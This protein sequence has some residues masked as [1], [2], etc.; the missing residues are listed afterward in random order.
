MEENNVK[1]TQ[2]WMLLLLSA[3]TLV[4]G[5]AQVE[6]LTGYTGKIQVPEFVFLLILPIFAWIFIK[7][8]KSIQI[9]LIPLD[10]AIFCY[11]LLFIVVAIGAKHPS[12]FK[13]IAILSYLILVYGLFNF[14]LPKGKKL[15]TFIIHLFTNLGV[16]NAVIGILGWLDFNYWHFNWTNGWG[17]TSYYPYLGQVAR[18]AAFCSTPGMLASL[19]GCCFLIKFAA[20]LNDKEGNTSKKDWFFLII[21]GIGIVLTFAKTIVIVFAVALLVIGWSKKETLSWFQKIILKIGAWSSLLVWLIGTHILFLKADTNDWKQLSEVFT[22]NH[23]FA[24][25]GNWQLVETN[26]SV[27]KRSAILVGCR[28]FPSGVGPSEYENY[29]DVLREE[30]NFPSYLP[31]YDPHCIYTGTFAELGF[32]G[33]LILLWVAFILIKEIKKQLHFQEQQALVI[34]IIACIVFGALDGISAD[35]RNARYFWIILAIFAFYIRSSPS[36][37]LPKGERHS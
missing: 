22:V 33:V 13:E 14:F 1:N 31:N 4:T 8:K 25:I 10:Y 24:K 16:L 2:N 12:A 3:Y 7:N 32:F 30:G 27:N 37:D 36:S 35:I 20:T 15:E 19:L 26:Y 9:K 11:W 17:A 34:G 29:I 18:A 5:F 6:N 21:I 23:P 28:F